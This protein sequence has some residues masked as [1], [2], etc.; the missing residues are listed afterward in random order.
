VP[1]TVLLVDDTSLLQDIVGENL[2]ELGYTVLVA[3]GG[4]EALRMATGHEGAIRLLLTDINMPGMRGTELA[5]RLAVTHPETR[6]VFMTGSGP[7]AMADP[8]VARAGG[9]VLE[10]P[11][12]QA[13]LAEALRDALDR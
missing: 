11:F 1:E 3:S 9:T 12:S 7:E 8:G 5:A 4:E 13:Q 10:K 2:L 6:V